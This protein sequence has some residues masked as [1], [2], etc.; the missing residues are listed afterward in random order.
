MTGGYSRGMGSAFVCWWYVRRGA[1][2]SAQRPF[3]QFDRLALQR[4]G[5]DHMIVGVD[6]ESVDSKR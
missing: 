1:V 4:T 6:I 3:Q 2:G 5:S